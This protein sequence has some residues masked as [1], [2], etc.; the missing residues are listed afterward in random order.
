MSIKLKYSEL[1]N[2]IWNSPG[3]PIKNKADLILD[4]IEDRIV[5][6]EV[7]RK[8]I[9]NKLQ[10]TFLKSFLTKASQVKRRQ[11][12][13]KS[14]FKDFL[15]IEFNFDPSEA[16]TVVESERSLD[17]ETVDEGL[18]VPLKKP[19]GRPSLESTANASDSTNW[20]R[21]TEL[22]SKYSLEVLMLAVKLKQK[23]THL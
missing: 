22:A 19:V 20:R 23:I 21:A 12:L 5:Y 3:T 16:I 1:C 11:D 13:F 18:D 17:N 15:E 10:N 7:Q 14:K 9:K 6:T 4:T 8:L 2:I